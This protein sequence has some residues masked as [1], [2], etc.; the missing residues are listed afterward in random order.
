MSRS[1]SPK[2][3]VCINVYGK[4]WQTLCTL[5]SLLKHSGHC[6]DTIFLIKE[7]DQPYHD[8]ID[9]IFKFFKNLI[10]YSPKRHEFWSESTDLNNEEER[11]TIRYQYGIEKSDKQFI[12]ITHNDVLYT[13]DV[14]SQMLIKI[15]GMA[16]VGEIGQCW[17]CPASHVGICSSEKFYEW[18]PTY[19]DVIN[20][21][22][23]FSRTTKEL[24]DKNFP[25]PLPECRLNEWACLLDRHRLIKEQDYRNKNSIFG[26]AN[27]VD[28]GCSWF[29]YMTLKNYQFSHYKEHYIH[30][31][32]AKKAGHPTLIDKA[33]YKLS[34]KEAKKYFYS[35]FSTLP[36]LIKAFIG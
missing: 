4:P 2:V 8:N 26:L 27:T 9:F 34:E 30:G 21:P 12:F 25:K 23:P 20:L 22:L 36:S 18:Q 32:W 28:I 1:R 6:I 17:N 19:E 14:L 16:G 10:I 29:K 24:I 35:N 33:T 13:G 15:E 7:R 5:K 3:D 31:Y 11:H